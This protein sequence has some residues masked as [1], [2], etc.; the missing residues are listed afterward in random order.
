VHSAWEGTGIGPAFE[1]AQREELERYIKEFENGANPSMVKHVTFTLLKTGVYMGQDVL[2]GVLYLPDTIWEYF[3]QE[4][5]MEAYA[6][7]QNELA[8]VMHQMVL[9]RRAFEQMMTKMR[10]LGLH[11]EDVK[12]FLNCMCRNCGGMFGGNYNPSMKG[13]FGHGPCQCNGPLSIWKTPLPTSD[14]KTQYACFN[15]ITKMRYDEAQDI[16]NKWHQQA[17]VENARAVEK[18]VQEIKADVASRKAMEDE[19][20]ARAI[21][22]KLNAIKGLMLPADLDYVRATVGPYLA[23]HAARNVE[24]GRLDRAVDNMDRVLKKIGPRSAQEEIS[25]QATKSQYEK[26]NA[27]WREAQEKRFPPIDDMVRKNQAH[28]AWGELQALEYQMMKAQ[29]RVL[30]PADKDPDFVALKGRVEGAM[31][32]YNTAVRDAWQ[33]SSDFQKAKDMRSAIAV[34]EKVAKDWEHPAETAQ[35]FQGQLNYDRSELAKAVQAKQRGHQQE[36]ARQLAQAIE[37]YTASLDIQRDDGLESHVKQLKAALAEQQARYARAKYLR[38]QGESLRQSMRLA[39]AIAAF[40]QSL[41][42]VPDPNLEQYIQTVEQ[43]LALQQRREA[44][45]RLRNE[46]SALEHERKIREA[47]AKYQ[48]SLRYVPDKNLEVYIAALDKHLHPAPAPAPQ[49]V[50]VAQPDVVGT[51]RH[52]PEA[53]WTVSRTSNGGW[54]AQEAGLGNASGPGH[55]TSAGTFRIDYTTRDGSIKGYYDI[56]FAADGQRGSGR[57]EELNGPKRAGDSHWTR[58][59]PASPPADT[60]NAQSKPDY[61]KDYTAQ[62]IARQAD[63]VQ[64]QCGYTGNRWHTSEGGHYGWCMASSL[65]LSRSETAGRAQD[66]ERCGNPAPAV[67]S[68]THGNAIFDNGNTGGVYNK[69][70]Q[71]TTFSISQPRTITRIVTYHWND[72]RG[73]SQTGSIALRNASGEK[74]GPWG[75]RGTPGQGGVPN[76]YWNATPNVRLPAGTYTVIDSD[77]A[78]WAQNSE[79]KGAGHTRIEGH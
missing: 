58:V 15:E 53:T 2:I 20:T 29:P 5:E 9:D 23:N 32:T 75:T 54:F 17:L 69:P 61:C 24:A 34:L 31:K 42:L 1:K 36:E 41:E 43:Q 70:T 33:K 74:W 40:R 39:E 55:W 52:N 73:T 13:E 46:G 48:E 11:D 64:R 49:P 19:E 44:A 3:T 67:S 12:P 37:S 16:F 30:P 66:L 59:Q 60:P 72:G 62:A 56:R 22:D 50:A 77:P 68:V 14:T 65:E 8:S 51:W 25:H 71:Q 79:S 10:K 28:R 57:V 47:I 27:N 21:S 76:A 45:Q 26:W 18:E 35:N 6:A 38:E 4:K 63:N 7:M 78:T